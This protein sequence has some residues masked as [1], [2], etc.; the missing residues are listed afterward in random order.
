MKKISFAAL[1]LCS[2]SASAEAQSCWQ[3]M[4]GCGGRDLEVCGYERPKTMTGHLEDQFR[5]REAIS[6]YKKAIESARVELLKVKD[7]IFDP[8]SKKVIDDILSGELKP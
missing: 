3:C 7:S 4:H 5:T 2:F 1:L 8:S 6:A